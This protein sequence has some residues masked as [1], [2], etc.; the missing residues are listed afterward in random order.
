MKLRFFLSAALLAVSA[1]CSSPT[2]PLG[3]A[4]AAAHHDGSTA[5]DSTSHPTDGGMTMGSGN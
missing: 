2:A 4:P 3:T 1:A 5:P